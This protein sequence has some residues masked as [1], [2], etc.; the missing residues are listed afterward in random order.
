[1]DRGGRRGHRAP[2]QP[3]GDQVRGHQA[4]AAVR[5]GTGARAVPPAAQPV[6]VVAAARAVHDNAV[7]GAQPARVHKRGRRQA[8][9]PVAD[10]GTVAAHPARPAER[11]QHPRGHLR[12]VRRLLVGRQR[13]LLR[14]TPEIVQLGNYHTRAVCP[15]G[16]CFPSIYIYREGSKHDGGRSIRSYLTCLAT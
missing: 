10:A 12:A 9:D 7:Q 5:A 13:I 1:V 4:A 14:P 16:A 6:P 2:G 11:L 8:R 15:R 3:E